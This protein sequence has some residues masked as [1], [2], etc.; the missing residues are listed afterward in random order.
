[1]DM[2]LLKFDIDYGTVA[3][4]YLLNSCLDFLQKKVFSDVPSEIHFA[5]RNLVSTRQSVRT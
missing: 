4:N 2:Y 1:M 5:Q 3:S